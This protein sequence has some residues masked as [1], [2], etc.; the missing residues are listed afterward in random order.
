VN[1]GVSWPADIVD[2]TWAWHRVLAMQTKLHCWATADPGRRFDDVFNLVH[3][4]AFLLAAWDRVR[5]NKGGRTAGVDG[6][7]PK[8]VPPEDVTGMLTELRHAVKTGK[9]TPVPVR[10][11]TIPKAGGKTR[12][13]GIPTM[14]DRIIQASLKL[15]L[16]PIFEADF[17]PCSYGFRPRR[18]AQDAV[19]EIHFYTTGNRSY[20]WVFEGDIKACFDEIDHSALMGRLRGRIADK[21]VLGLIRAFLKAG[22]LTE[23]GLNRDTRTGTPQGGI[24]SP[25]LANVALSVLDEHFCSKWEALGPEWTRAKHLRAG[26]AT[27][28]LIRYADDFVVLVR[29]PRAEAEALFG[30][31]ATVLAPMGLRLSDEKTHLTHID[32]GFDF[33]G[34]RIQRRTWQGRGGTKQTVYT[35]P[36]KRSLAS[37]KGKIRLLTRRNAHRTLA[38]LL[39]RLN[40]AIRGWCTYFQHGV[41]KRTFSYVDHFAFWRIVGWLKKRHP[42]LNTH[43]VI[44]R[45]LPG[46]Q[47][48]TDGIEF[49]R[50]PSVPVTRYRYRGTRILNPWTSTPAA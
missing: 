45:Y 7:V 26:G 49:F 28:K 40:P 29:G 38:D 15:V 41:S 35:Y 14:T 43:T 31:V 11:R 9:F 4:P 25:L 1:T 39:R 30:E 44:R 12:S 34:W 27:M 50:A 10:Q 18:R 6:I 8:C 3:D 16:E 21:R 24:L 17:Q 23:D 13:L 19:A 48:K 36:S 46:W 2:T 33:L 37:I 5:G 47:I 42:K 32:D 22:V 20:E